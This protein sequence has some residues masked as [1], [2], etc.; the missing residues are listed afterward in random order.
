MRG[1]TY[2]AIFEPSKTGYGVYFPDLPGCITVGKNLEE[3]ERMAEEAL[4]LHLWG[5]E[6]DNEEIPE[7][8]NPPF[9]EMTDSEEGS[10]VMPVTV[11][12]PLVRNEMDNKAVKKTL[13]IPYWLNQI[14]EENKVN[15]SQILQTALK[16]CLGV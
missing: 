1:T 8:T 15:F 13:T 10:F 5:M 9:E 14:A 2:F 4:G 7:A 12:M 6:K 16:E 3:A 11:Y